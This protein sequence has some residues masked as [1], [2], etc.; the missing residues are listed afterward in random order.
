MWKKWPVTGDQWEVKRVA[1]PKLAQGGPL[2]RKMNA[3]STIR[4]AFHFGKIVRTTFK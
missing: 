1:G 2:E 4:T 3:G